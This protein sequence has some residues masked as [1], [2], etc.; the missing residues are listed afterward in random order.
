MARKSSKKNSILRGLNSLTTNRGLLYLVLVVALC[1][2][3]YHLT[4]NNIDSVIFLCLIGYLSTHF[5]KN[6][7]YV[8]V[9][10]LVLTCVFTKMKQN[11]IRYFEGATSMR[12]SAGLNR[13]RKAAPRGR[14]PPRPSTTVEQKLV[15]G[16]DDDKKRNKDRIDHAT[17][18]QNAFNDLSKIVGDKGIQ[19][20]TKD[21]MELMKQQKTMMESLKSM[22]PMI[23]STKGFLENMNIK[24]FQKTLGGGN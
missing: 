22:E 20:M 1:Y 18:T 16:I 10:A 21:T 5:T 24:D 6:M 12:K 11:Q 14:R 2:I 19:N 23:N 7:I 9:I 13:R 4:F 8:L 3:V 15:E 17:T